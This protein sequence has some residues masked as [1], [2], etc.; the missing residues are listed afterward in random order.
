MKLTKYHREAFVL[1]VMEDVPKVDYESQAHALILEDSIQQLPEKL[2]KIARDKTL[3]QYLNMNHFW[4]REFCS[5]YVF[6]IHEE[7]LKL[8]AKAQ[9]EFD[10]LEELQK[11]QNE[12]RRDLRDKLNGVIRSCTTDVQVRKAL[13]E[14]SKYLPEAESPVD[15]TVPVIANLVADLMSM[16]WPKDKEAVPA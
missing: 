16:G 12:A 14:F 8:S 10:K 1:A 7:R 3:R 15:R 6:N 2:Q 5:L 9:A 13:P 4:L 11:A